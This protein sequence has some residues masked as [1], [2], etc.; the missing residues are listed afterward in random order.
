MIGR[1]SV[2]ARRTATLVHTSGSVPWSPRLLWPPNAPARV[3]EGDAVTLEFEPSF[4]LRERDEAA[5]GFPQLVQLVEGGEPQSP[6][7]VEIGH[8]A[9]R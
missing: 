1:R 9:L 3:D 2:I 8:G 5:A 4:Q 6:I 7:K